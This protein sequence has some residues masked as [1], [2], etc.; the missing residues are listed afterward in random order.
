MFFIFSMICFM[1]WSVMLIISGWLVFTKAGKP[2]WMVLIP[3][4]SF[5]V[6]IQIIGGFKKSVGYIIGV[7]LPPFS[8]FFIPHLAFG[9]STYT[10]PMPQ[11][12]RRGGRSRDDDD[13]EEEEERPRRPSRKR[14]DEDDED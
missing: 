3:I 4:Y 11:T 10:T 13:E 6:L 14:R 1:L 12:V 8:S 9:D 5:I 2:G 7:F